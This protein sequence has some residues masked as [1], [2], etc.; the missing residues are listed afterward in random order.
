MYSPT[1]DDI[2]ELNDEDL[3]SNK[4]FI[5]ESLCPEF[6]FLHFAVPN[7]ERKDELF[8]YKVRDGAIQIRKEERG[9]LP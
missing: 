1:R 4:I 9:H 7:A 2:G 5:N 8:H 6:A 3:G